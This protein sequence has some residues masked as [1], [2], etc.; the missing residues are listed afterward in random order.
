MLFLMERFS[1]TGLILVYV[2]KLVSARNYHT[3]LVRNMIVRR[4]IHAAGFDS[5]QSDLVW[6]SCTKSIIKTI[7]QH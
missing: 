2:E 6:G 3:Q 7:N 1:L 5:L 4:N